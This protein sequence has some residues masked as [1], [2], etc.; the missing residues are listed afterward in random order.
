MSDVVNALCDELALV[1][2]RSAA[3]TYT[4]GRLDTPTTAALSISASVQPLT[5]RDLKRLPEGSRV[6]DALVLFTTTELKTSGAG[7]S[8]DLIA[9]G[10][11]SYEVQNV[12]AWGNVGSFW[13]AIVLKTGN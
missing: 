9:I 7:Q 1:V 3:S 6:S 2:T 8:P 12:E 13:K 5:G 11:E 10:G 4:G